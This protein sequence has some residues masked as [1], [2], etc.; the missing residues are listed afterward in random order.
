MSPHPYELVV[1]PAS[2]SVC[3]GC[4]AEFEKSGT[5]QYVI[6]HEDRRILGRNGVN[7]CIMFDANFSATYYHPNIG[8]LR[9]KNPIFGNTL[10]ITQAL[11]DEMG[12]DQ[13]AAFMETT[14]FILKISDS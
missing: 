4:R 3:Y 5:A 14:N 6:K 7:G 2:V 11:Y 12:E 9:K 8:H 13:V 1:K 10:N